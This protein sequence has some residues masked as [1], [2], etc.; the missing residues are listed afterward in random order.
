MAQIVLKVGDGGGYADGDIVDT[1]N[2]RRTLCQYAQHYCHPKAAGFTFSGLRPNDS[3]ARMF[4]EHTHQ[5][6]I[7]RISH[8]AWKRIEIAT[9]KWEVIS[10]VPNAKGE[11]A[12][13]PEFFDRRLALPGHQIFGEP[14]REIYYCGRKDFSE[15]T[16]N[17]VWDEIESRTV[18]RRIDCDLYPLGDGDLTDHFA[19]SVDDFDDE[20]AEDLKSP[21][22]DPAFV[23]NEFGPSK[24]A[25]LK[26]RK[27]HVRWKDL[28]G[29]SGI[30]LNKV[31]SPKK[32]VN[33]Q[34]AVEFVR[35][36]I[37]IAKLVD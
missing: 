23:P 11:Y 22:Y 1:F 32:L 6:R 4:F 8:K 12:H 15:A 17:A 18:L 10:D 25:I 34:R 9:G 33:I 16:I 36:N 13:V 26:K 24:P 5:Y 21:L 28:P 7:E 19:I 30:T 31:M 37:V 29:L 2:R 20:T 35:A 27:H 3:L 14:G